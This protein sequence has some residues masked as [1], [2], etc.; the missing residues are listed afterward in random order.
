M[1]AT[2]ANIAYVMDGAR[3]SA[4]YTSSARKTD[5]GN[6]ARDTKD[7]P[8]D[9]FFDSVSDAQTM[10]NARGN[11]LCRHARRF[12]ARIQGVMSLDLSGALP[13][14]TVVDDGL[15]VSMAC[16]VVGFVEDFNTEQTSLALWG[17]Y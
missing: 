4:L 5:Y 1:P 11:L 8:F 16:A 14:A 6:L 13:A 2:A 12:D 17:V 7:E 10:L 15:A 9:S 3:R